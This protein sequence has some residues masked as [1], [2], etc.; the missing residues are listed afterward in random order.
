MPIAGDIV[1]STTAAMARSAIDHAH[2]SLTRRI[3]TSSILSADRKADPVLRGLSDTEIGAAMNRIRETFVSG[4]DR[5]TRQANAILGAQL[6]DMGLGRTSAGVAHLYQPELNRYEAATVVRRASDDALVVLD[7]QR[8]APRTIDAWAADIDG[9]P[10]SLHVGS[11]AGPI[12][13]TRP[14]FFVPMGYVDINKYQLFAQRA[15]DNA[16]DYAVGVS[17]H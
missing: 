12:P 10:N 15:W 1:S 5:K 7:P 6:I 16:A 9:Y 17:R 11:P 3:G 8:S 14:E 13:G 4:G 2:S